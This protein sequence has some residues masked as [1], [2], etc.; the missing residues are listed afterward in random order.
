[1]IFDSSIHQVEDLDV[2][3]EQT[4]AGIA[5]MRHGQYLTC[6]PYLDVE[7]FIESGQLVALTFRN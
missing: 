3:R 4:R 1:M 6:L 7:R 5:C 2:W